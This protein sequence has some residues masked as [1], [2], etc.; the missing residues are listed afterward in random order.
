MNDLKIWKIVFE[1][2]YSPAAHLFDNRG[3]IA[4]KWQWTS[5]LTEWRISNN[6]VSVHNKSGTTFLNAGFKNT[7][8]VME[9]PESHTLFSNQAL[10]FSIWVLELLQIKKIERVGLRFIQ[11]AKRQHFKLLV[12]KMREKLLGLSEEDWAIFGGHPEDIGLPL[13]LVLGENKANFT[14]GPMKAEQLVNYF[15]S[16]EIKSK[17]PTVAVFLDFDLY[18]NEPDFSP[19]TYLEKID[20]FLKLG[21]QQILEISNSLLDRHGGFK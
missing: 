1:V 5:D 6:Q 16:S 3:K 18:R 7:S 15:E 13:T 19:E 12:S 4:A 17:I 21:G 8:V 14:L 2:R 10:E 11:L 9:L 20:G